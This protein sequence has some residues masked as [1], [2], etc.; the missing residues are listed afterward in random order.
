MFPGVLHHLLHTWRRLDARANGRAGGRAALLLVCC[1]PTG[2]LGS[3]L[4]AVRACHLRVAEMVSATIP[5]ASG[6][7]AGFAQQI[8][9]RPGNKLNVRS[10]DRPLCARVRPVKSACIECLNLAMASIQQQN[11]SHA[12]GSS[13]FARTAA[14][15]I[16]SLAPVAQCLSLLTVNDWSDTTS[17]VVIIPQSS[18]GA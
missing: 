11:R 1:P 14:T 4:Q 12:E 16:A 10:K 9:P 8:N 15:N 17:A 5:Q 18:Q 6:L 7:G 3:G 13:R 2:R